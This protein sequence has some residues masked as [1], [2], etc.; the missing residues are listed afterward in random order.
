MCFYRKY[1]NFSVK[2]SF[3]VVLQ[4]CV[5]KL[6]PRILGALG[7]FAICLFLKHIIFISFHSWF[8]WVSYYD[9]GKN[10]I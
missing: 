1:K 2:A 5:Y 3:C 4:N 7:E 6:M 9:L 8:M 10:Q